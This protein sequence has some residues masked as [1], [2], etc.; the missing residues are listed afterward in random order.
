MLDLVILKPGAFCPRLSGNVAGML[1]SCAQG[2]LLDFLFENEV[3][4][5]DKS[6]VTVVMASMG[7]PGKYDT[8]Y[9][10]EG[11]NEAQLFRQEM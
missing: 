9:L 6:A 3:R 10:I 1:Y 2:R 11:L 7:Y 5:L 8:G 4:A